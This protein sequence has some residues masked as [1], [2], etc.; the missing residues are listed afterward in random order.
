MKYHYRYEKGR[1]VVRTVCAPC[2]GTGMTPYE[3]V[4]GNRIL[5][6]CCF[7]SGSV[8]ER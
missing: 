6:E 2:E 4:S 7:G 3:D 1:V 8:K 5:C